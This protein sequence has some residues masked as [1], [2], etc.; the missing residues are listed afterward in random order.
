MFAEP[1]VEAVHHLFYS[2][3]LE[4][5]VAAA[6]ILAFSVG[7]YLLRLAYLAITSAHRLERDIKKSSE[8]RPH[9]SVY[10]GPYCAG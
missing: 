3:G 5:E 10:K 4:L 1:T 7:C 6:G 8:Q 9:D 2:P